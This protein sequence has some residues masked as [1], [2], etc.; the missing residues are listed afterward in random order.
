MVFIQQR[1][2]PSAS[3]QAFHDSDDKQSNATLGHFDLWCRSR[4]LVRKQSQ[5]TRAMS[6]WRFDRALNT[7]WPCT[8]RPTKLHKQ[9]ARK[10]L[11][12]YTEIDA[13]ARRPPNRH[14]TLTPHLT[15]RAD[16][17]GLPDRLELINNIHTSLVW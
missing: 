13:C 3:K 16:T 8:S 9:T 17:S 6:C 1:S 10:V 5:S 15:H 4:P 7:Q 2:H 12:C 11:R 14:A